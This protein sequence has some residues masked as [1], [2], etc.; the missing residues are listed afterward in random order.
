M[1]SWHIPS[2]LENEVRGRDKKC[3]YCGVR[4]VEGVLLGRSRKA[5]ATW[6]H[7][8]ND[9]RV[10]TRDNI[11]RCCVVCNASKGARTLS[12]WLESDY[13]KQKRINKNTVSSIIRKALL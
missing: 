2:W 5:K 4:L 7:I 1:N 10:V 13:C 9:A 8:I 11:A 12:D 6:E 3:V